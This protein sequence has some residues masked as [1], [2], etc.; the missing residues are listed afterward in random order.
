LVEGDA[1]NAYMNLLFNSLKR[2]AIIYSNNKSETE[3]TKDSYVKHRVFTD[4]MDNHLNNWELA[5]HIPNRYKYQ[6][7]SGKES[8]S[9][10]YIFRKTN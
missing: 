1:F 6:E 5:A 4:W 8:F 2:F 7:T 3:D 9:A 10:F